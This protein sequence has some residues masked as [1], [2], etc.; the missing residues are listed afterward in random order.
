LLHAGILPYKKYVFYSFDANGPFFI[1]TYGS[2]VWTYVSTELPPLNYIDSSCDLYGN[3]V[4]ITSG[5]SSRP[6]G[7]TRY[8]ISLYQATSYP[9]TF[10][11]IRAGQGKQIFFV[12]LIFCI[13]PYQYY[14][15]EVTEE[16]VENNFI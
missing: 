4:N 2:N 14:T 16:D 12:K 7:T 8:Y 13:V 11:T 9:G 5:C 3:G 15:L 6:H 1:E 10:F